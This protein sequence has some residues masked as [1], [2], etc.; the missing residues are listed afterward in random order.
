MITILH[1]QSC[2]C[3]QSDVSSGSDHSDAAGGGGAEI[4]SYAGAGPP[5][6]QR[7]RL[8]RHPQRLTAVPAL[9][10]QSGGAEG[11]FAGVFQEE[12]VSGNEQQLSVAGK[13]RKHF[14][15]GPR[16]SSTA[17]GVS[18]IT[19]SEVASADH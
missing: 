17:A 11:L 13:I 4:H 8:A 1:N 5:V 19:V 6:G 16:P 10:R 2:N 14:N 12:G 9:T 7:K 18:V 15:T 3:G